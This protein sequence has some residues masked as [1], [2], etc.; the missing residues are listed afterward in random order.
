MKT[1]FRVIALFSVLLGMFFAGA[2][3]S[4]PAQAAGGCTAGHCTS[5]TYDG[6]PPSRVYRV[7]TRSPQEVFQSGFSSRGQGLSVV[8]HVLGGVNQ[9][10]DQAGAFVSTTSDPAVA[11]SYANCFLRSGRSAWIYTIRADGSFYSVQQSLEY[12]ANTNRNSQTRESAQTALDMYGSH[13]EW[14]AVSEIP[15]QNILQ[16]N[17]VTRLLG[18]GDFRGQVQSVE[19]NRDYS[20]YDTRGSGRLLTS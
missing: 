8:N 12:I 4:A 2:L 3:V 16:A 5:P 11:T 19:T 1:K 6:T 14:V 18:Q 7:D 15:S 20:H 17:P 10:V 9:C 13:Q